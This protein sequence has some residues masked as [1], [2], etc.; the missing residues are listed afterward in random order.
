[1][2]NYSVEAGSSQPIKVKRGGNEAHPSAPIKTMYKGGR[3]GYIEPRG[4]EAHMAQVQAK[5]MRGKSVQ[6]YEGG[7]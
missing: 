1:M 7:R 2:T 4:Y 5:N 3:S 6:K